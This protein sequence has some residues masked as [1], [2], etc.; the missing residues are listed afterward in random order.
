MQAPQPSLLTKI[1]A[2]TAGLVLL[3]LGFMFSVVIL[4]LVAIAGLFAW[5]YF[6]WKTRT[7]RSAMK[8]R[9]ADGHVIDGEAVVIDETRSIRVVTESDIPQKPDSK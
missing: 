8:Q 1:L 3:A 9:P 7:L 5:G 2:L 4:A 6:W